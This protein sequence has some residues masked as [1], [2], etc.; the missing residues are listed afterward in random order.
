MSVIWEHIRNQENGKYLKHK[1]IHVKGVPIKEGWEIKQ[2][3]R[4]T[5]KTK[6]LRET[7]SKRIGISTAAFLC[8]RTTWEHLAFCSSTHVYLTIRKS[9]K[10]N[11]ILW[12]SVYSLLLMFSRGE[13]FDRLTLQ[14]FYPSF[15]WQCLRFNVRNS[16]PPYPQLSVVSVTQSQLQSKNI[17]RNVSDINNS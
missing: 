5:K 8:F 7:I 14:D 2:K 15:K 1:R 11:L 10:N 16:L 13:A 6:V 17:K 4:K 12:V 9:S 3:K